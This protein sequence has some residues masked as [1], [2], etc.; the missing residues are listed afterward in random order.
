MAK[1]ASM[2]VPVDRYHGVNTPGPDQKPAT[3]PAIMSAESQAALVA[4]RGTPPPAYEG[5]VQSALGVP[6]PA[7]TKREMISRSEKWGA[8]QPGYGT[9]QHTS[10]SGPTARDG[11]RSPGPNR[12]PSPQP[13]A[14]GQYVQRS[15]SPQ[16]G[17]IPRA[18]SPSPQ[19]QYQQQQI[20]RARS[21]GPAMM[22]QGPSHQSGHPPNS[23]QRAAS[24][25][26]YVSQ[27]GRPRGQSQSRPPI[28]M[29]MQLSSHDVTRYGDSGSGRSRQGMARPSSSYG[30]DPHH[31]Q[32]GFDSR[33]GLRRERSKSM[34]NVATMT[35]AGGRPAQAK[36]LY[37]G[38]PIQHQL[39]PWRK[40]VNADPFDYSTSDVYLCSSYCG[41]TFLLQRRH[42]GR[43]ET[44]RRRM[45][46]SRGVAERERNA[47]RGGWP[48]A[49]QL[50]AEMLDGT[51]FT[52][53]WFAMACW[54]GLDIFVIANSRDSQIGRGMLG[55]R[56]TWV[57]NNSKTA[58][59]T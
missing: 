51:K 1:Q 36:P 58:F 6:A 38:K 10:S 23:Y 29:E 39:C 28:G 50:S 45:V 42:P 18:I 44:A 37:F 15:R 56:R 2:R 49:Q 27:G 40:T 34:A 12:A 35:G 55:R 3:R 31:Q 16:P 57:E 33:A 26:P 22:Q 47:N 21:P 41:G 17:M 9:N 46:G 13:Q 25:N 24:P 19:S 59:H 11:R 53:A 8:S 54:T 5:R 4:Q 14:Q 52:Y 43:A 30:G 20:H 48:G 7:H 32:Q